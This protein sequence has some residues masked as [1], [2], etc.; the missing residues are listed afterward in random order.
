MA[1]SLFVWWILCSFSHEMLYL[2]H[3]VSQSLKVSNSHLKTDVFYFTKVSRYI[4]VYYSNMNKKQNMSF[5]YLSEKVHARK[6]SFWQCHFFVIWF[7]WIK[8]WTK[9]YTTVHW[10]IPT[11]SWQWQLIV[12][13]IRIIDIFMWW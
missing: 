5:I 11:F 12:K 6:L 10:T 7:W 8:K 9:I 1:W 3:S 4:K 2:V 13:S